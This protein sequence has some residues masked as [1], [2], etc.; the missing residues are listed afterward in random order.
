MA[1]VWRQLLQ[2][3]PGFLEI[4]ATELG[5][6][7]LKD[8]DSPVGVPQRAQLDLTSLGSTQMVITQNTLKGELLYHCETRVIFWTSPHL[9]LPDSRYQPDT[10]QE[11]VEPWVSEP[12]L[13]PKKNFKWSEY[14]LIKPNKTWS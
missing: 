7:L 1:I 4:L 9:N 14:P 3:P 8:V 11:L 2:T 10:H 13:N 5:L 6:P 12:L